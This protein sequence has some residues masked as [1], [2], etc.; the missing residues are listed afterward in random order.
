MFI[1]ALEGG[2][3]S[4]KE[5]LEFCEKAVNTIVKPEEVT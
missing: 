2:A 1:P 5:I 3:K 4:L